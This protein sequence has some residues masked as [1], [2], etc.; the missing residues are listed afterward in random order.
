[1]KFHL[2]NFSPT[3]TYTYS[4]SNTC[5]Q[6]PGEKS[7][8]IYTPVLLQ[9][10]FSKLAPKKPICTYRIIILQM[11]S[12]TPILLTIFHLFTL[13]PTYNNNNNNNN[14]NNLQKRKKEKV[15]FYVPFFPMRAHSPL[16]VHFSSKKQTATIVL[17]TNLFLLHFLLLWHRN[18]FLTVHFTG[19][20]LL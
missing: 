7:D 18:F 3:S 10:K 5:V 11:R 9:Q 19:I 12:P 20:L 16:Q 6:T 13:L 17:T 15:F 8:L 4:H 14:N 2:S 1:M